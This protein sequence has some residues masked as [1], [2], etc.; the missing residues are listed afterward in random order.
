MQ[1]IKLSIYNV[2]GNSFCTDA[3]D[4]QIVYEFI[5]KAF[6]EKNTVILDFQNIEMLTAAFLNTLVGQLYGEYNY[7]FIKNNLSVDNILPEDVILLK[8]VVETAKLYYS[9]NKRLQ[10][11]IN[12]I[13]ADEY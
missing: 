8:R 7:D 4:G 1:R 2:I 13:L 12:E 9:D 3:Y 6:T 5:K 11:S 10:K